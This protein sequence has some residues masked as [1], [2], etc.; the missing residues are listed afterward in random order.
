MGETIRARV[1]ETFEIPLAGNLTTGYRWEAE[2]IGEPPVVEF[3]ED[4]W[5]AD[6]SRPGAPGGQ[7]L[8]F[9]AVAAGQGA[10][11]LRYRRPWEKQAALEE[12]T[13][14]LNITATA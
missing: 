14:S 6:V 7:R 10:V 11:V 4:I 2:I 8:R 5:E 9:R 3:L 12:R 1:G 13:V